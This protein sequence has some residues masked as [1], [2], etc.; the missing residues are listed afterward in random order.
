MF[1]NSEEE[2]DGIFAFEEANL[3]EVLKMMKQCSELLDTC[4]VDYLCEI[5]REMYPP[6]E[7]IMEIS[8][9]RLQELNRKVLSET[10]QELVKKNLV[11]VSWSDTEN[12]FIFN[13]KDSSGV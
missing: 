6:K 8:E 7:G 1:D 5:Y 10:L 2:D 3:A 13:L 12:D 11:D 9:E 4:D